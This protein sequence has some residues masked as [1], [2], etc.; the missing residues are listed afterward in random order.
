M[1]FAWWVNRKDADGRNVGQGRFLG[2]ARSFT[3]GM[4]EANC[5]VTESDRNAVRT[6]GSPDGEI[7]DRVAHVALNAIT[8]CLGIATERTL[9]VPRLHIPRSP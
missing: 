9:S 7:V 1:N 6:V 8:N 3:K 5:Q 2:A 4:V